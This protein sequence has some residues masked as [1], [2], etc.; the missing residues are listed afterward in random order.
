MGFAPIWLCQMS[1]P[2]LLHLTTLTTV[3]D[4]EEYERA[5]G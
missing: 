4:L 3:V 1:P 2:P 5:K